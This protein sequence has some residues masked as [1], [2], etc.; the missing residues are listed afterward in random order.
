MSLKPVILNKISVLRGNRAVF[1]NLSLELQS[2]QRLAIFGPNGVG[3]ST[4]LEVLS[5]RMRPASGDVWL[6]GE[7]VGHTDLRMLRRRIGVF[8]DSIAGQID[9]EATVLE[10]IA[11]GVSGVLSPIWLAD[12]AGALER[13]AD[14]VKAAEL[15]KISHLKLTELSSGQLQRVLVARSFASS[16][17]LMVL[18]EPASHLDFGGREDL[19]DTLNRLIE[20]EDGPKA[21]VMVV[22]HVEEIPSAVDTVVLMGN[23]LFLVGSGVSVLTEDNLTA[24]FGRRVRV[25][26]F[27]GRKFAYAT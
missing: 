19:L 7:H 10:A 26:D 21:V 16:V 5:A 23:G 17:E 6:L 22:H 20:S 3:K 1:R 4:L 24:V 27:D 11:T 25:V 18:D 2:G 15:E 8:S 9:R 14:I 13:A 12:K